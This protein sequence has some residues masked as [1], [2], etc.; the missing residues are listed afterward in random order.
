TRREE[1]GEAFDPGR[2]DRAAGIRK[3]PAPGMAIGAFSLQ[4]G[5][6]YAPTNIESQGGGMTNKVDIWMPLY[7]RDY[8]G[9]TS[10]LTTEQH[11]AYMLLIM[12]DWLNGPPPDDEGRADNRRRQA[13][14]RSATEAHLA[15][16]PRADRGGD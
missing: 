10:R 4:D 13:A 11:G 15:S 5:E 9:A 12:D 1:R 8:L 14:R 16:R 3:S 7:V 6:K 2:E